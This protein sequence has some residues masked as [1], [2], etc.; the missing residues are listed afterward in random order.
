MTNDLKVSWTV[1]GLCLAAFIIITVL[2]SQISEYVPHSEDE[3]AY[4]FQAK[5]FA[6]NRLAAPTPPYADAFWTPFVVDYEG[7]RFGKYPIGW[8]LLLSLGFRLGAPWLAN[9]L[10][11][12]LTL[13]L[14]ARLGYCFYN[15]DEGRM[16][17]EA[18]AAI[19]TVG[20]QAS[21]KDESRELIHPSSF[22]LHPSAKG[23]H[24]GL[25]AAGLGLITPGFLLLSSSFLSHS[26]SLFWT[27]LALLFLYQLT[28][29]APPQPRF[30][31]GAGA[32]GMALGAVF[33]T[34]PFAAVGVGGVI[35]IFL[36]VLIWRK[37]LAWTAL[38]WLGLGGLVVAGLS[39][40]YWWMVTGDPSFNAY[41]L[42][43]PYDQVGFGPDI[44]PLGYTLS[45]G[46]F[47]N[48]RLKL[49]TLGT[50]LF[51]WP[52]WS[53]LLF[54]PLPFLTRRANRWDWLLLGII[55]I[56]IISHTFYWSFG[57]ADG[58]FP[59]YYYEALP[60]FL[61]LTARGIYI[62]LD[63]LTRWGKPALRWSLMVL[64]GGFVIYNLGWNLPPRLA[65]QK[66]K[67]DITPAQLQQV[68]EANLPTPALVLVKDMDIWSDFAVPF[69]A[70]S[71]TLDGP[72]VYAIDWGGDHTRELRKYFSK[73]SCWE[74]GG[75]ALTPCP[76]MEEV[77][78]N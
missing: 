13:A 74:L 59:R 42:V 33:L 22:I 35:G 23:Q 66:G 76:E 18:R 64:L 20:T 37:E 17:E 56:L 68:K 78:S 51:G 24:I 77:G 61:L 48:T 9:T 65:A 53:N 27:T 39:P 29:T 16:R 50:S 12:T 21:V 10:L 3:V 63:Y 47:I 52:G 62:S 19:P 14:I 7:Q 40:L 60:G 45:D 5:V 44:G 67:Y 73:R 32:T 11:A 6:Q 15:K 4:I 38:L 75:E 31:L 1:A 54:L 26:A 43:W 55:L 49:M 58:G 69:I 25:L 71:P 72:V 57:G 46:I 28:Q 8:P 41:L 34:R 36:I 70:N 2:Y 30:A